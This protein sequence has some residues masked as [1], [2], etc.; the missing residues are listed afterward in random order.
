VG[1]TGT[2]RMDSHS[3]SIQFCSDSGPTC[4]SPACMALKERKKRFSFYRS[5][6]TFVQHVLAMNDSGGFQLDL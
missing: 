6:V 4:G 5:C 2:Q 3:V 1:V